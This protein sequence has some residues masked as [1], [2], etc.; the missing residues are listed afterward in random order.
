MSLLF[1]IEN[2]VVKP[3]TETLLISPFK[4]IWER[5]TNPGKFIAI[6]EFTYIEFMTSVKKSNPYK[7]YQ[8]EERARRLALDI[9]K[10][11][12][13]IPD[14]LVKKGMQVLVDFQASASVTYNYYMSVKNAIYKV[15]TFFNTFDL[16]EKNEKTGLPIYK[17]KDIT[18]SATDTEKVLQN[19]ATLQEKVDN[20]LFESVKIKGQKSVSMFAN[21]DTM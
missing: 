20:E 21:P 11:E 3:Y 17:P 5:D 15:Q 13:Y 19:L 4:E 7:G 2:K 6:D 16:N 9:M 12:G 8:E 10:H 1:T 18:M 14:D